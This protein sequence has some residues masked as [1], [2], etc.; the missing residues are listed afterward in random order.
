MAERL[1]PDLQTQ[2]VKL[3]QLQ[4]QL[5]RLTYERS[6]IESEL[7]EVNKVLEE[8]SMISTDS[9]VYKIVGNVLLKKDKSSIEKELNDRKEILELRSRTY[10]KQ[11]S[12]LR[13]QYEDLQKKINELIQKYNLQGPSSPPKA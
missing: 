8:L 3:Q 7:R 1:P 4:S 11:E 10:Q 13:K 6:V 5:D 2:L 12:L 9:S